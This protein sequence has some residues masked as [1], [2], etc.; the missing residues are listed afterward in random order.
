MNEG[1]ILAKIEKWCGGVTYISKD[2]D[3]IVRTYAT[4][5]EKGIA[6]AKARIL[7]IIN[8]ER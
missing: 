5:Y 2:G 6:D 4:G 7:A 3:D 8:G 1:D